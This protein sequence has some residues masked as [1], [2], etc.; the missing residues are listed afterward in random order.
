[1][2]TL[3]SDVSASLFYRV[4]FQDGVH[5]SVELCHTCAYFKHNCEHSIESCNNRYTGKPQKKK[6]KT[7]SSNFTRV[8]RLR[9]RRE[10]KERR[11]WTRPGRA[12]AWWNNFA[13]QV[14]KP[15]QWKENFRMSRDSLYNLAEEL[16]PHIQGKATNMRSPVGVVKQ[17]ACTLY[18][19]SDEG[20]L[21]KTAN[22]FELSQSEAKIAGPN[23]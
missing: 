23:R 2:K 5:T 14:V 11:F 20:R 16:R 18:Y 15:E 9:C 22:A 13:D 10:S 6:T 4:R 7:T 17:V 21:R 3:T 12:S 1:M 8:K 19:L